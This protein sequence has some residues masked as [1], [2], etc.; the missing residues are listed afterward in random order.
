SLRS[1]L[2]PYTTLFRSFAGA[3]ITDQEDAER[4][5]G[6]RGSPPGLFRLVVVANGDGR[7]RMRQNGSHVVDGW[8]LTREETEL[9]RRLANEHRSEEHTS[10]LQSLTNI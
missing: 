3:A 6:H 4:K 10:E 7:Q 8:F 5:I 2:F 1:P 9:Q